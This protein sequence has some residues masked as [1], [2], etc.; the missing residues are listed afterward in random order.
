MIK[1]GVMMLLFL[2]SVLMLQGCTFYETLGFDQDEDSVT[3]EDKLMDTRTLLRRANVG[4]NVEY[5]SDGSWFPGSGSQGESQGS[6][7]VFAKSENYYYALTNYHVID[8]KDYD[9][10]N[11]TVVPSMEEVE[12]DAEV[13]AN[14]EDRDLTILRF[15][16]ADYEIGVIKINL[17]VYDDLSQKEMLLAVGNPSA[18]NSIVTFGQYHGMV[19]TDDVDFKVIY[20][21]ALIYPGN[22]GG[23]LANTDGYLIGINTWG[24]SGESERNLAVPLEEI[25]AFIE[26]EGF[27][28]TDDEDDTEDD[29]EIAGSTDP[30][31]GMG[32]LSLNPRIKG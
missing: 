30:M 29:A 31:K 23:A 18:V 22:S 1:K 9:E 25:Y 4:V 11:V 12:I 16:R 8:P 27:I 14:D 6:G 15:E 2:V 24:V 3:F 26:E 10:V 20:H 7:V 19:N 13:V 17:S 28:D 5:R 21:S 32:P